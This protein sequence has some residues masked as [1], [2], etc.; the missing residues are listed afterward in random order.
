VT[1]GVYDGVGEQNANWKGSSAH[2]YLEEL[3]DTIPVVQAGLCK[4]FQSSLGIVEDCC[5]EILM[6]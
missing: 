3:V 2:P 6:V 5:K 1:E 4:D